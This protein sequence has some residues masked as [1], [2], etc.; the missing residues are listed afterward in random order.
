MK[1]RRVLGLLTAALFAFT[2]IF[3]GGSIKAEAAGNGSSSPAYRNVMYY[4]EWSIYSGQNYFYP[5]LIDGS[6]ITHLNFAFLDMD[7]NGDLVL[8]DEHADFLAI[9]PEQQ[10]ITYGEPY[11]GVLGAMSI[12]RSKY[13]NMKI[14]ISVGG[15]TRSGDFGAVAADP[16]KRAHFAENIAKFVDYLGYDFVD[17]DWEYPTSVRAS[18]PAG[19]GVTIDEGCRGSE[20]DTQN[21]TLLLRAI[22]EKLDELGNK[23]GKY[24]ELSAA[25]SASPAMMAKINY[26]EVL[27]VVDFLNMMTYDLNGAWN[28]YTGHQTALYTNPAYDHETQKDGVFSV[29]TCVQYLKNTYGN[30]IDYSKIVIGV[31]PYTRGWAG[32]LNDGPDPA[33]PGLYATAQPNS[34]KSA[35]GTTSG[36]FAYGAIDSLKAQY[37]LK[38]YYDEVAE[39]A[40][41]YNPDTGYFFTCD[42]ERSVAAKGA[43]VKANGLGGLISWMASLDSAN[44]ITRTM[45]Q[46]LYGNAALPANEIVVH[47]PAASMTI[48]ASGSTYT[49]TI[50][51]N[52][53][54]KESN[55][56]LKDAE[57]FQKTILNPKL[58]IETKS[59]KTLTAGSECGAVFTSGNTT[60][61]DLSGVYAAKSMKPGASHTFTLN[62]SG[63]A[64]VNDIE[65][66]SMTERVLKTLDEFG[67]QVIYGE[68]ANVDNGSGDDSGSSGDDQNNGSETGETGDN[69][70]TGDTGSSDDGS[71][72][73]DAGN[74]GSGNEGSGNTG[75]GDEGQQTPTGNYPAWSADNVSYKL[76]DLVVYEGNVYECTYVHNSNIAWTPTAAFVLWSLRSDLIPGTDNGNTNT[77]ETGTGDGNTGDAGSGDEGS[78]NEGTGDNGNEGGNGE[79]GNTGS[80]DEGSGNNYTGSTLLGDH[81]VTGYWHNFLNGSTALRLSDV[82]DYYDLICVAFTGNTST[83]GE[84]TFEIDGDLS[85]ALGGY[86]KAQFINDIRTLKENGQHVIISVGGAEGRITINDATSADRFANGLI[87]IIEEYGFEGVDIDLEGSAVA[88]VDYIAGALRTVHDHFGDDFIITMAPETY[89]LQADRISA[90]DITTSYLRLAISI[91]DILTVCYPQY[92]NSGSMIGYGGGVVNPG[93]ADFITSLTTL[94]IEAGLDDSQVGVGVPSI[95]RA[96]GSGY[97]SND[98]LRTAILSLV[99]GT[100]SG[101][102]TVP[103]AYSELKSVMT[104]SIN[105]DATNGYAWGRAMSALMDE[106]DGN[107]GSGDEGSGN[108]EGGNT[109]SGDEG[110]GNGESG[111]TGSGDNGSGD[112]GSGDAGNGDSGNDNSGETGGNDTSAYPAWDAGTVYVGGDIAVYNGVVYR[113]S[114]WN[115]NTN[116]T[117]QGEWG[118]WKVY[119]E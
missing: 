107:T 35:D 60:V 64:D 7:A 40:Y 105:W 89:Y 86:S 33:H 26:D 65:G 56:A 98:T 16:A 85:N 37:G 81:I 91:K 59:G 55:T 57:L 49:F 79:S 28:S 87:N 109:G 71:G 99:N 29:D 2:G 73:G 61:L 90:N 3:G 117:T 41:Y 4:G 66:V 88:G 58:Y 70:N 13:P 118:P 14:G 92:Y 43:Y 42:N 30:S 93:T 72:N 8:C 67:S 96:A 100:S 38:E 25:M 48:T 95:S 32:V 94:I 106:I 24:Y 15:W 50:K 116:P 102:F 104:W 9:L 46:S 17:I 68:G 82:P 110:N 12:L 84:V 34:V 119:N 19:N 76:G 45:K 54:A 112:T 78:G 113:A 77:G 1:K 101:N 111:D 10:G 80:D 22:R 36:T 62:V 114:W 21:F 83:P 18:D 44:S 23:N 97:V 31:A 115:L 74:E 108:N 39:A 63:S 11:A 20:A 52:E 47:T 103:R 69:G 53:Q 5:G 51:N 75:S 27:D 6:Q